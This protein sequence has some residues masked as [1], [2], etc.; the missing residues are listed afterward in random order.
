M[1]TLL[2][3]WRR[4]TREHLGA[5]VAVAAASLAGVVA[6]ERFGGAFEAATRPWLST[7]L[8]AGAAALLLGT[9]ILGRE[10]TGLS[11]GFLTRLPIAPGRVLAAKALWLV[12][13]S[14]AVGAVALGAALIVGEALAGDVLRRTPGAWPVLVLPVAAAGWP[15][16][17]SCLTPAS[18]GAAAPAVALAATAGGPVAWTYAAAPH[19][20]GGGARVAL[21]AAG[22]L[23]P[24]IAAAA[25]W[26]GPLGRFGD[27]GGGARRA[28]LTLLLCAVPAWGFAGWRAF[29][30]HDVSLADP[31][32]SMTE[33]TLSPDG[34][35]A[36]ATAMRDDRPRASFAF[37]I[38]LEAGTSRRV[39]G[40]RA[41]FQSLT[42][43]QRGAPGIRDGA[44]VGPRAHVLYVDDVR[45]EI[46][47]AS[48]RGGAVRVGPRDRIVDV[49]PDALH[50]ELANTASLRDAKSRPV[51]AVGGVLYRGASEGGAPEVV[52][53]DPAASWAHA[54]SG[55]FTRFLRTELGGM[56]RARDIYE[57]LSGC[58]FP[59]PDEPRGSILA[60][61]QGLLLQDLRSG[62]WA[63]RP[64]DGGPE[65]PAPGLRPGDRVLGAL[66]LRR[67]LVR[68]PDD[69]AATATPW[70]APS[71]LI[72]VDGAVGAEAPLRDGAGRTLRC[73]ATHAPTSLAPELHRLADG[74]VVLVVDL[75]DR[76]MAARVDPTSLAVAFA[77]G[78]ATSTG[79]ARAD[80]Y[81]RV[82]V[83]SIDGDAV[84]VL[85]DRRRIV[86]ARFGD[87]S[88]AV[89]FPKGD[90]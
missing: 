62:S 81:A 17:A 16:L 35:R 11:A 37:E 19:A 63:L 28:A 9:S 67:W 56:G 82:A 78:A 14:L 36:W 90:R 72:A 5:L 8:A 51:Y 69:G 74:R 65:R 77:E 79:D 25:A 12:V 71:T 68:R 30:A 58:T 27:G 21:I 34:R 33:L 50:D 44:T 26:C 86:S 29:D 61:P 38:D 66:D 20:F 70:R 32:V 15:V 3:L 43:A 4:E 45:R 84:T 2:V 80:L 57:P 55:G 48:G 88:A 39:G 49:A 83:L 10:A 59:L 6:F 18:A 52:D 87:A 85:V 42:S 47:D 89:L 40:D 46:R 54:R 23:A 60:V 41:A 13:A 53:E 75:G 7:A 73:A 22:V 64:A 1:K 31:Q 76:A 24:W